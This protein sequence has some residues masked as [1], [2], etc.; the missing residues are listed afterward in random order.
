MTLSLAFI[1]T[2]AIG[3]LTRDWCGQAY[4]LDKTVVEE[5]ARID[6][7]KV[8]ADLLV[9]DIQDIELLQILLCVILITW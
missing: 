4:G 1:S 6:E 8:T 7:I 5:K 2:Q 3:V 9:Q